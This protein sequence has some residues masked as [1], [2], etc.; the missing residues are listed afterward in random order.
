MARLASREV[1]R[2]QITESWWIEVRRELS[3]GD[4]QRIRKAQRD[5]PDA[6]EWAIVEGAITAWNLE[7]SSGQVAPVTV[8]SVVGVKDDDDLAALA[9]ALAKQY[10]GLSEE[11]KKA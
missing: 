1:D 6:P 11:T 4:R 7:G 3:Y 5:N 10:V 2:I 8:A 9:N